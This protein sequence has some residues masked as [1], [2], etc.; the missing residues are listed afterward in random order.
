MTKCPFSIVYL[1]LC[2]INTDYKLT[3]HMSLGNMFLGFFN[4]PIVF[5]IYIAFVFH[6]LG[7]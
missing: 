6:N 7:S 2:T 5:Y 3:R 1:S 4:I